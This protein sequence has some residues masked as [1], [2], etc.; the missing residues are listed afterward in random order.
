MAITYA[1]TTASY[2]DAQAGMSAS[3]PIA[4]TIVASS[5]S[6]TIPAITGTITSWVYNGAQTTL[7]NVKQCL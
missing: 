6:F 3:I 4:D 1:R 5:N 2:E 7:S